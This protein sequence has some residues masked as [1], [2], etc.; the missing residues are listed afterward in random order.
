MQ[1]DKS[2]RPDV[3][4]AAFLAR[5]D[6]KDDQDDT[7][8]PAFQAIRD[9]PDFQADHPQSAIELLMCPASRAPTAQ[10]DNV[11]LQALPVMPDPLVRPVPQVKTLDPVQMVLTAPLVQLDQ[12]D[13]TDPPVS[14]ADQDP[15]HQEAQET[16]VQLVT[17]DHLE[18][19]VPLVVQDLTALQVAQVQEEAQV[20]LAIPV[21]TVSQVVTA[22]PVNPVPT[23]R[24]VSARNIV[25]LMAVFSLKMA[26]TK[27]NCRSLNLRRIS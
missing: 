12:P 7:A 17:P 19:Q 2:G 9:I 27:A 21:L 4:D 20:P 25:R 11:D 6:P 8:V 1:L 15:T 22:V 3:E 24:R 26:V 5:L 13:P 23:E 10:T 18:L 16:K 14:Q